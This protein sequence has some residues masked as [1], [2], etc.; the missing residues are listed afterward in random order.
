MKSYISRVKDPDY[1]GFHPAGMFA[2]ST[3]TLHL[4]CLIAIP[5]CLSAWVQVTLFTKVVKGRILFCSVVALQ[6]LLPGALLKRLKPSTI[7]RELR[8]I[9]LLRK[10]RKLLLKPEFGV[11]VQTLVNC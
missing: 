5:P 11:L 2:W 9:T 6:L 10:G 7:F 8:V 4:I 1:Y 3:S